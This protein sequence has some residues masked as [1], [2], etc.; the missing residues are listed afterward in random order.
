VITLEKLKLYKAYKGDVDLFG[1]S[2]SVREKEL[3]PDCDW[4][5][6]ERLLGDATVLNRNLGSDHRNTEA[7]QR[8][9]SS[10]ENEEAVKY[11]RHLAERL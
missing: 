1:R 8:L 5:L 7:E 4:Y 3:M 10:C 9:E 11:L 6:I 2:G